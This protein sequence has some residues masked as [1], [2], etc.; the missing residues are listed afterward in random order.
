[1]RVVQ[2]L[3][4]IVS[5]LEIQQTQKP[6]EVPY[7]KD[8]EYETLVS[9]DKLSACAK[10]PWQVNLQGILSSFLHKM[11]TYQFVNLRVGGRVLYSASYLLRRKSD[12]VI[13]DSQETQGELEEIQNSITDDIPYDDMPADDANFF[14]DISA[15]PHAPVE[16]FIYAHA[17]IAMLRKMSANGTLS[18]FVSSAFDGSGLV[19]AETPCEYIVGDSPLDR[20]AV[21]NLISLADVDFRKQGAPVLASVQ[22]VFYKKIQLGALADAL[23]QVMARRAR[24]DL[25][26]RH[27]DELPVLPENFFER[28]QEERAQGEQLMTQLQETI[29]TQFEASQQPVPFLQLIADPTRKCVVR[30]LLAL[31][32]LCNQKRAEMWQKTGADDGSED[33]SLSGT[34]IFLAPYGQFAADRE[35]N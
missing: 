28:A 25:E 29:M 8:A 6:A 14:E 24:Q 7:W 19:Q 11:A 3:A 30:V 35:A 32:H 26:P 10:N 16:H 5:D 21:T 20:A 2:Q 12:V 18:E 1:V 23:T 17:N 34:N 27:P 13:C 33:A 15:K 22:R 31:L 4:S 9:A